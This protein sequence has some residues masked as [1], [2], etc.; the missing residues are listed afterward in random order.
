MVSHSAVCVLKFE[1]MRLFVLVHKIRE[2][3]VMSKRHVLVTLLCVPTE[4]TEAERLSRQDIVQA[5]AQGASFN[6]RYGTDV[7]RSSCVFTALETAN[8]FT[9]YLSQ[10][11]YAYRLP[12]DP[13]LGN[14]QMLAMVDSMDFEEMF[15]TIEVATLAKWA[16][17]VI[18]CMRETVGEL[19]DDQTFAVLVT[20]RNLIKLALWAST[21]FAVDRQGHALLLE[22]FPE[23][24][25]MGGIIFRYENGRFDASEVVEPPSVGLVKEWTY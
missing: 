21:L 14:P 20:H 8:A 17:D 6:H 13:R 16:Q 15:T 18:S 22:N 3:F 2:E 11:D 25:P 23:V 19:S 10:T 7:I 5:V 4:G 24:K 9:T 12:A 1:A